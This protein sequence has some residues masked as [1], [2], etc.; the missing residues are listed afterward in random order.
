MMDSFNSIFL[1]FI[2]VIFQSLLVA[3][4]WQQLILKELTLAIVLEF[5]VVLSSN[6]SIRAYQRHH[7]VSLFIKVKFLDLSLYS[8]PNDKTV[9]SAAWNCCGPHSCFELLLQF[10]SFYISWQM[11][12]VSEYVGCSNFQRGPLNALDF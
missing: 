9:C 11:Y 3:V 5:Y 7:K 2:K 10:G 1:S 8:L 4:T 6:F 12:H